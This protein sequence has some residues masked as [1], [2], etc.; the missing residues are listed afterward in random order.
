[1]ES[2][3]IAV[4][5][6]GPGGYIA[7]IRAAQLNK[8]VALIEKQQIGGICLNVGCI[9][10]KSLLY[11]ADILD[12]LKKAHEFGISVKEF[13]FDFEKIIEKKDETIF[14]LRKSLENLIKTNKVTII[15]GSALFISPT[16]LKVDQTTIE[17]KNIIIAS[18]SYPIDLKEYPCDH[19]LLFNSTSLLC[20]KKL[21]KSLVIIGGGYI[22]CEFASFY[23]RL[24][25]EVTII[26]NLPK[27]ISS[28]S[29]ELSDLLT[30]EFQKQKII[31]KTNTK[32][33]KIEKL[34]NS[35]KFYLSN[36]EIITADIAL[37]A[38]GR[39]PTV[40]DLA[41]E[42]ANI[43][44]DEK[45]YIL[46]NE[47]MET[48]TNNIYAI[49]DVVGN[50]MLAH[51]ASHQ[52]LIAVSNITGKEEKMDYNAIPAVIFTK[53]EIATVGIKEENEKIKSAKFPF[54]ALG[55]SHASHETYGYVKLLYDVNTKE[56]KGAEAVGH[57]ASVLIGD[58]SIAITNKLKLEDITK[59]I[60]A[61][62]TLN[63]SWMECANIALGYP[64]NFPPNVKI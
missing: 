22:G 35:I 7:A 21:P 48:S 17:A 23:S 39:K 1:M 42:K 50:N 58:M 16:Q 38:I 53:P 34:E 43:K 59:S 47:K 54:M 15:K 60:F 44:T 63:E 31:I 18:G 4:I 24:N 19:T 10:T 61:H 51:V 13:S 55:K 2:F 25:V 49:G 46:V 45:G 27:L 20:H 3:D 52:G 32:V 41:L 9:P 12:T 40:E 37:I 6:S 33:I 64:L 29:S 26:E 11:N 62:P 57:N 36:D 28:H 8:K 30:K 5:G 14:K 56:I